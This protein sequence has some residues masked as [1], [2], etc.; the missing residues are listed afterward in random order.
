MCLLI[1]KPKEVIIPK[2][3]LCQGFNTNPDGAGFAVAVDGG[4]IL[5][6]GFFT[7]SSFW[8]CYKQFKAYPGIIH[9][10]VAT[11]GAVDAERCHPFDIGNLAMAHNGL[12][13]DYSTSNVY[14]DT[15]LF[16]K[17]ISEIIHRYPGIWRNDVWK[18][19][20][21]KYIDEYNK[22]AFI[23]NFGHIE[24]YNMQYGHWKYGAWFSNLNH[25][26]PRFSLNKNEYSKI[27]IKSFYDGETEEKSF[28]GLIDLGFNRWKREWTKK[29]CENCSYDS[30]DLIFSAE[31]RGYLCKTCHETLIYQGYICE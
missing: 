20:I 29:Y 19:I 13:Q 30:E 2:K 16:S 9:F 14:S 5:E 31:I 11:N 12:L 26:I 8:K 27:K 6:K 28:E 15:Q 21:E 17:D 3:V 24:I 23:D 10:R 22:L 25:E 18:N 4:L 1:A 7:F